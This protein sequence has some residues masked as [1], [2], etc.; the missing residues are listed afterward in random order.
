MLPWALA[1]GSGLLQLAER[2]LLGLRPGL[3]SV[4]IYLHMAGLGVIL[5]SSFWSMLNEEF[6]PREAKRRFGQIAAG[7]TIG[8]VLGGLGAE[9]TV[10]WFGAPT[11]ML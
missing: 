4:L 8:G 10:A 3:A 11:L 1:G 9:R 7:G 2:W 6:D 5:L